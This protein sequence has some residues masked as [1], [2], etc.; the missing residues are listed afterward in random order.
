LSRDGVDQRPLCFCEQSQPLNGLHFE[1]ARVF[2]EICHSHCHRHRH[3]HVH[4]HRRHTVGLIRLARAFDYRGSKRSLGNTIFSCSSNLFFYLISTGVAYKRL[5]QSRLSF[6]AM[7]AVG[8]CCLLRCRLWSFLPSLFALKLPA[9][10]FQAK[11][12]A[13]AENKIQ[14]FYFFKRASF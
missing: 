5:S 4:P 10:F 3:R 1:W 12:S 6:H 13:A 7:S 8:R 14:K 11:T 9:D 2:D